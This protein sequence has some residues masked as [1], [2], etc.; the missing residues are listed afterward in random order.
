MAYGSISY[1]PGGS[2]TTYQASFAA[3]YPGRKMP[4]RG[5]ARVKILQCASLTTLL[6]FIG[7]AALADERLDRGRYLVESIAGCGN[8]HTPQGP[9]G[10]LPG[11]SLAGGLPVQDPGFTAVSANITPDPET[12]IG[13]WT[14]AQITL[15]IREGRRP[16]GSLIGPPMPFQQF[17]QMA[18]NDV[19]AIVSYLRS[20]PPVKNAVARTKYPFPL[21]PAWGPPVGKIPDVAQD[22]LVSYGRYLAG[23]MGH[24]IECH[25]APDEKGVPD[26]KNAL[27]AGG[28]VFPGPWGKSISPNL[29]PTKLKRY[30][31]LE[32]KKI[33]STGVRPDGSRLQPPMGVPYYAKMSD[34]DL[35][36][37]VA[38]L[39][40]LPPK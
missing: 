16:D 7:A 9:N 28:M 32:V 18:D 26:T 6:L 40:T 34:H 21:P 4:S 19:A 27:G 1:P 39:R 35:N 11:M 15:A 17:R 33:I 20:V 22:D 5:R 25:S 14:D 23:P 30:S 2:Q 38:Y 3:V 12:G 8:C 37:L 36:A 10:P 31:D 13:K 24:C 29:T